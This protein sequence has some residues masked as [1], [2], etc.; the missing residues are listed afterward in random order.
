MGKTV[1]DPAE[2]EL[3]VE[4]IALRPKPAFPLGYQP[5]IRPVVK[6]EDDF[7]ACNDA[8]KDALGPENFANLGELWTNKG[9]RKTG[10]DSTA[11]R[12]HDQS[13][14]QLW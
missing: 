12:S 11:R 7:T 1:R 6:A 4:E 8:R 9:R 14:D 13:L 3:T 10:V 5:E 2:R